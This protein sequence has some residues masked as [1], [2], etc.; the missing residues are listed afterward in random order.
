MQNDLRQGAR[1]AAILGG[2]G[3][4]GVRDVNKLAYTYA[5]NNACNELG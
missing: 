3:Q 4:T 1:T 2:T 5:D